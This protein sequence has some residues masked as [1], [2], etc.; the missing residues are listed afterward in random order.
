MTVYRLGAH[1]HPHDT[2]GCVPKVPM[3]PRGEYTLE[4][5]VWG[6]EMFPPF[7][8]V[9]L[10]DGPHQMLGTVEVSR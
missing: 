1:E 2:R 8:R 10:P 9:V 6:C 3:A 7:P 5:R 4:S